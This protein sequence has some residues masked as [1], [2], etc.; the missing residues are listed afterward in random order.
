[1]STKMILTARRLGEGV[2][3]ERGI[4]YKL[5]RWVTSDPVNIVEDG[6]E[7]GGARVGVDDEDED[8][9]KEEGSE[10]EE[11]AMEKK[12]EEKGKG[13]GG[14]MIKVKT[15]LSDRGTDVLLEVDEKANVRSLVRKLCDE[16]EVSVPS[17]V[18]WTDRSEGLFPVLADSSTPFLAV[19]QYK[20]QACIYGKS[21]EGQRAVDGARLE[22]RAR[23][24]RTRLCMLIY[25]I[26]RATHLHL[27]ARSD[28][29]QLLLTCRYI[30]VHLAQALAATVS[31]TKQSGAK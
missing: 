9:I 14:D 4:L 24:Q 10:G 29:H 26:L 30:G 25:E 19:V 3:D 6:E 12:G 13:R 8:E 7:D 28:I 5:P 31:N 15:R 17:F 21:I 2:W 11:V 18:S 16:A 22:A 1:M 23:R 20:S 27:S